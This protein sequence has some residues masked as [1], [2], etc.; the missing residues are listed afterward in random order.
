MLERL[1]GTNRL[2]GF[3]FAPWGGGE[4]PRGITFCSIQLDTKFRETRRSA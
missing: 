4:F 2:S 1:Q 3:F